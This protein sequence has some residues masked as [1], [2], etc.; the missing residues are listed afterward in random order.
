MRSSDTGPTRPNSC[1]YNVTVNGTVNGT[2]KGLET[3]KNLSNLLKN[4]CFYGVFRSARLTARLRLNHAGLKSIKF[5]EKPL[6][7]NVFA[8]YKGPKAARLRDF[9]ARLRACAGRSKFFFVF[10]CFFMNAARLRDFA[11]RLRA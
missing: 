9:A 5:V 6:F 7:Y 11:A 10:F 2:V 1:E 3:I 8:I 4:H